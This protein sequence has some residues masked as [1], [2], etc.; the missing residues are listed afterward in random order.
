VQYPR[1]VIKMNEVNHRLDMRGGIGLAHSV[2]FCSKY[3]V[4]LFGSN[5]LFS[6]VQKLRY[7]YTGGFSLYSDSTFNYLKD[8]GNHTYNLL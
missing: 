1:P 7:E 4:W 5:V 3:F 6:D 8:S 2:V